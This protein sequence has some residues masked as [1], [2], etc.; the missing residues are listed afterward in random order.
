[1]SSIINKRW[2]IRPT[3][4]PEILSSLQ[5]A[6]GISP[7]F[8]RLLSNRG[9]QTPEQAHAFLKPSLEDLESPWALKNMDRAVALVKQNIAERKKILIWGDYDVDGTTGA[10]LLYSVL[11]KI[12]ADV[13]TYIPH[14]IHEGYGLSLTGLQKAIQGDVSLLITVDCGVTARKEIEYVASKGI[15]T[16]VVDHHEPQADKWPSQAVVINPLQ[17]GCPS[18][19]KYLTAVGLA[20]KLAW[21]LIGREAFE[22]V[23]LV[24]A[25]AVADIAPLT[26][27][28]RI[29]VREGLE[30]INTNP[31]AGFK[32]LL[33]SAGAGQKKIDASHFGFVIGP[34]INASGRMSS[35]ETALK[36]LMTQEIGEAR[37]LAQVLEQAN[38]TRQQVERETLRQAI[39][40]VTEQVDF[41]ESS[42]IIVEDERWHPGVIGIVA[43]RLVERF[44]RPS[45]VIAMNQGRGK[46]SGRSIRNF[47]L[48]SAL[49]Q[50]QEVLEEFGGHRQAA[51]L[52]VTQENLPLFKE[53]F[54]R[55]AQ[56]R[57]K[58]E[59]FIP[60]LEADCEIS[61][62]DLNA[63][64]LKDLDR[65]APYGC[66]NPKPVFISSG[67]FLKSPPQFMGK[68]TVKFW[69]TDHAQ[70]YQAVGFGM[71]DR[72]LNGGKSDFNP[73]ASL[74]LAYSPRLHEWQGE[75]SLELVLEDF[76]F[77]HSA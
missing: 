14:R 69:V 24:A 40:K 37:E 45:I 36:L 77:F 1:M 53:T 57:L 43:S 9:I 41:K 25:G 65:L 74:H 28:N 18:S 30:R 31:R 72:F 2:F 22:H 32:A 67:L 60:L 29:L 68:N 12:G 66:G 62:K 10:S 44:Y 27:E 13:S 63:G 11:S 46:G 33:E 75:T 21:A 55:V 52:T 23:E 47:H 71:G 38:R 15:Q 61:L 56:Q 19:Y 34:R 48:V 4:E 3:P 5:R 20:F 76:R 7:L 70:I 54:N 49:E 73:S 39:Q 8:A 50:C 51:G 16:I 26:G 64:L 58:P 17:P 35:A 59:D 42:V 6:L